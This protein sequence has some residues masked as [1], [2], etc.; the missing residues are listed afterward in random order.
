MLSLSSTYYVQESH[1][2]KNRNK[3]MSWGLDMREADLQGEQDLSA[4]G[5]RTKL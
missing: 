1:K 3:G 2:E 5:N 4:S